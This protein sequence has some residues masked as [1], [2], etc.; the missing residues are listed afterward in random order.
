MQPTATTPTV[1]QLAAD[2]GPMTFGHI[3]YSAEQVAGAMLEA[4]PIRLRHM[5]DPELIATTLERCG[6]KNGLD[7]PPTVLEQW[8]ADTLID[9]CRRRNLGPLVVALALGPGVVQSVLGGR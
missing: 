5:P 1:Q 4:W 9:E 8:Q 2:V 6:A 3:Q 7:R